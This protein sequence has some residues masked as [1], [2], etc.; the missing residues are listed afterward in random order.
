MYLRKS[1]GI[2]PESILRLLP[3]AL[4]GPSIR[5]RL[6]LDCHVPPECEFKLA[7]T[8]DEIEQAFHLLYKSHIKQNYQEPNE[9]QLR[10]MKHFALPT[11]SILVAKVD[12]HVVGTLTIIRKSG[13][14]LPIESILDLQDLELGGKTIAEVGSLAFD[15]EKY[16]QANRLLFPLLKYF[17]D[18]ISSYIQIDRI[19][20]AVH[21]SQAMFYEDILLFKRLARRPVRKY[22]FA[23]QAPAIG[24]WADVQSL[25]M[26][27]EEAYSQHKSESNLYD[28]FINSCFA[29][30]FHFP[31]AFQGTVFQPTMS[32]E[33]LEYFFA[34]RSDIFK[35][36]STS[37]KLVLKRLYPGISYQNLFAKLENESTLVSEPRFFSKLDAVDVV[38]L[39]KFDVL[40]I[41]LRGIKAMGGHM[42]LDQVRMIRIALKDQST[43]EV[44]IRVAWFNKNTGAW[45]AEILKPTLKWINHVQNYQN[46]FALS[47]ESRLKA[48]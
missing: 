35:N 32:A 37:E 31:Q 23:N 7:D 24:L 10:L 45:G 16:P 4:R 20:I 8:R 13:F 28:Y 19:V 18:Y 27:F 2:S 6:R 40:D 17:W 36:L 26:L 3:K 39:Q 34:V 43:C 12:G 5:K 38:T 29:K 48:V 41:S 46:Q 1:T 9:S 15:S 25:P 14:A 22:A 42:E 30:Q 47:R 21:P 11:T 44:R 33:S